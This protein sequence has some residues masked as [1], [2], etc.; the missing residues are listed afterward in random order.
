MGPEHHRA[1]G[2]N[3]FI[4][5]RTNI[6]WS[7]TRLL[8]SHQL[9]PKKSDTR[10]LSAVQQCKFQCKQQQHAHKTKVWEYNKT[11][12][13]LKQFLNLPKSLEHMLL[14]ISLFQA[15]FEASSSAAILRYCGR[16]NIFLVSTTKVRTS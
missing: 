6:A 1:T 8:S 13:A 5:K 3:L 16:S 4:Y 11:I 14:Y 7:K 2:Y 12:T 15:T 9:N 10:L